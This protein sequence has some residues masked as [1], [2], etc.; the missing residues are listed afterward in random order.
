MI[1]FKAIGLRV[2]KS[3]FRRINKRMEKPKTG[4][5]KIAIVGYRDVLDHFDKE[6][7]PDRQW[8][9]WNRKRKDGTREF[10]SRRPTKRGG[11]KLLQDTGRLR[12]STRFRTLFTEAHVYNRVKYAGFHEKGTKNMPKR[13]FMWMSA[14]ARKKVTKLFSR[15]IVKGA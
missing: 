4:L 13:R 7:G 14:K 11:K 1:K 15:Y 5:D 8:A 10:F 3:N 12:V 2:V 9:R 6:E